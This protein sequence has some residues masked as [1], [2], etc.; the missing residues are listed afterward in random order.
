MDALYCA[1]VCAEQVLASSD[2]FARQAAS[3]Q[4]SGEFFGKYISLD[5]NV[6]EVAYDSLIVC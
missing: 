2:L 6:M 5:G 3:H 4:F 1:G